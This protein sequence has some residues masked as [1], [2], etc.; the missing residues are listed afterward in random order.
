MPFK[1]KAQ[2]RKFAILLR[3]GDITQE[4]Y[5]QWHAETPN[6]KKLPERL[7]KKKKSF[8]KGFEKVSMNL[9]ERA[10][11]EEG[12]SM[13]DFIPGTALRENAETGQARGRATRTKGVLNEDKEFNSKLKT[14]YDTARGGRRYGYY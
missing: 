1:S 8:T 4:Q 6:I 5:D 10:A 14:K 9:P 2:V 12:Y 11:S 3:N 7:K 13:T